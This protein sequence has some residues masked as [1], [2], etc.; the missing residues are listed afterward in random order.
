MDDRFSDPP[1]DPRHSAFGGGHCSMRAVVGTSFGARSLVSAFAMVG[2]LS[3]NFV[4]RHVESLAK[5]PCDRPRGQ[6]TV[7]LRQSID[8]SGER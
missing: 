4:K 1:N 3:S 6:G 5:Q 8:V 7:D 2:D